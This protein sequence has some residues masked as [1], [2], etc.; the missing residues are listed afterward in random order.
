MTGE[1]LLDV[2]ATTIR[3]VFVLKP[4]RFRDARGWFSETWNASRMRDCGLDYEFVQDN[5]SFSS[6]R[7]TVRGLHFQNPPAAQDK[8]VRVVSGSI[9]DVAVDIRRS[10]PTYGQHVAIELTEQNGLQLLIPKGFAHGF[11]TLVGNTMVHYKVTAP[12]ASGSDSGLAFDDPDLKIGWGVDRERAILSSKDA[13]LPS[14]ADFVSAF[15]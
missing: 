7:G 3:G 11:L 8:L 5:Q 6:D 12:Y 9:L 4:R 10:S 15:E 1:P 13:M 2:C 14:F